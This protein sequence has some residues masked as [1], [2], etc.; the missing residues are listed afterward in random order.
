MRYSPL[1]QITPANVA[2]LTRAWTYKTG[3]NARGIRSRRSSSARRCISARRP[4]RSSRSTRRRARKSG[5]TTRRPSAAAPTAACRTGPAIREHAPRLVQ[6]GR[7]PAHGAR[8][9]DGRAS[10]DVR[11]EWR[12]RPSR[13]RCGQVPGRELLHVVAARD[14]QGPDHPGPARLGKRAERQGPG[15]RH[16]RVQCRDRRARLELPHDAAC[17]RARL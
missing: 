7:Q 15:G 8:C 9:E 13:R 4:R 11:T 2:K 17:R 14:L 16:P 12:D 1:T 5:S 6:Y 3:E 10:R